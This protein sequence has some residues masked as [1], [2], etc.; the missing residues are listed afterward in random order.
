MDPDAPTPRNLR[1]SGALIIANP[2]NGVTI[3]SGYDLRPGD[4]R[5]G[6]VMIVNVGSEPGNFRLTES[7]AFNGF[8]LG[9]M[10]L[11]I[12]D[13]TDEDPATVFVGEN[14]RLPAGGI[15]LGRFEPSQSRRFRLLAMLNPSSRRPGLSR[16]AGA[17]YMW[18]FVAGES[19]AVV[20]PAT[21]RH[22][23]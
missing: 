22:R 6:R 21:F 19:A 20:S 10:T 14:G 3:F 4:T 15:D 5:S 8:A 13:M 23:R 17:T 2:E 16:C 18:D 7:A 9:E 1:S 12:D 11:A